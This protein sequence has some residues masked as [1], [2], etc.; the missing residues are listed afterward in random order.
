[1]LRDGTFMVPGDQWP[2][3]LWKD[4]KYDENDPWKGLLRNKLVVKV[5]I[6]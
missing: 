2:I 6:P 3:F 5:I 4:F 1:M